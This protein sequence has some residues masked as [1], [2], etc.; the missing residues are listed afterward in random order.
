MQKVSFFRS[1]HVKLVLIY[2]L[3]ILIAMQIIGL[4]FARE[5]EETL[6]TNFTTSIADRMKLVEFSVRE[7]MQKDRSEDDP[8][9]EESLRTVLSGF[10][11][12]DIIE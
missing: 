1:I 9:L 7:E 5:L 6:K 8:K 10:P 4:Y 3:L 2:V 12:D 11:S